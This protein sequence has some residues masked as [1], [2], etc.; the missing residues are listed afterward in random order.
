MGAPRLDAVRLSLAVVQ[1]SPETP[2]PMNE[3]LLQRAVEWLEA[4]AADAMPLL[5]AVVAMKLTAAVGGHRTAAAV[6]QLL[7]LSN[8]IGD[9]MSVCVL[10]AH[11]RCQ[12]LPALILE[13]VKDN[14]GVG[15]GHEIAF[16]LIDPNRT[17]FAPATNQ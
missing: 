12:L 16:R 3:K 7:T 6:A 17:R 8:A 15:L 1:P 4:L 9:A 5:V 13:Q 14:A 11:Q 2:A 10:A